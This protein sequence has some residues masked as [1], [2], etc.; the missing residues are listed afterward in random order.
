VTP[1]ER[2]LLRERLLALTEQDRDL[3]AARVAEH[4][5]RCCEEMDLATRP[6]VSDDTVARS[7]LI[8]ATLDV[9]RSVRSVLAVLDSQ[10][11]RIETRGT[12]AQTARVRP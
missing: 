2:K 9:Y 3:R 4:L 8:H 10:R 12:P 1:G 6:E 5:L 11:S 7:G